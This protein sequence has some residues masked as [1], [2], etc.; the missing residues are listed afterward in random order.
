MRRSFPPEEHQ[1]PIDSEDETPAKSDDSFSGLDDDLSYQ[2]EDENGLK[3]DK[4]EYLPGTPKIL[5]D[6]RIDVKSERPMKVVKEII[7]EGEG[8]LPRRR[9]TCALIYKGTLEDGTVFDEQ[10]NREEPFLFKVGIGQVIK[11]MDI[12]VGSMKKGEIAKLY[13]AAD[14]AYQAKGVEGKVPPNSNL[15]FEMEFL[16]F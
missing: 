3:V 9:S 12:G 1:E 2:S 14:Y 15:I 4:S 8:D 7:K 6:G 16:W 11:G 13:I 10:Q 5:D